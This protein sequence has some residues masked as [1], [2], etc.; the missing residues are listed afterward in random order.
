ME[1]LREDVQEF[2]RIAQALLS[3]DPHGMPLTQEERKTVEFYARSL[4][5]HWA[6]GATHLERV[7]VECLAKWRAERRS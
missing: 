1:P 7:A 4:V 6:E 5:D 2:V 3:P